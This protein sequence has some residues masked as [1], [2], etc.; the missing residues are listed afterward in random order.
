MR[1]VAEAFDGEGDYFDYS[2]TPSSGSTP[3]A[4]QLEVAHVAHISS[5]DGMMS[6][7]MLRRGHRRPFKEAQANWLFFFTIAHHI[8]LLPPKF[9]R[10]GDDV[11]IAVKR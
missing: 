6:W 11:T 1:V 9:S 10:S 5:V 8:E 4:D 3:V 7:E 2:T